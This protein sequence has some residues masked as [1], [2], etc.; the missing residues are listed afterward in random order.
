MMRIAQGA[1]QIARMAKKHGSHDA[2]EEIEKRTDLFFGIGAC[3]DVGARVVD[4]AV[5]ITPVE[6]ERQLVFIFDAHA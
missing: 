1:R 4:Y 5:D 2:E 3:R 6:V